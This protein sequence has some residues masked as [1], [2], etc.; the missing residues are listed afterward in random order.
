MIAIPFLGPSRYLI[1][2]LTLFF[3]WATVVSQWNLVFGV[4]GI[5]SLAQMAIFAFGGFATA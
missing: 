2:Q 3:L 5:F 4:G 1:G